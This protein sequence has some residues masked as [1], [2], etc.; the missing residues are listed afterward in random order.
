MNVPTPS[1]GVHVCDAHICI[2]ICISMVKHIHW[3]AHGLQST[4]V[5]GLAFENLLLMYSTFLSRKCNFLCGSSLATLAACNTR[6][7]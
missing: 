6:Q 4:Q 2:D 7:F 3:A 1:P 5:N